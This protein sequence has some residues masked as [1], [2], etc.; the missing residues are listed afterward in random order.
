MQVAKQKI[1]DLLEKTIGLNVTAFS[2][3]TFQRALGTR[4]KALGLD[5]F[6]AYFAQVSV[7]LEELR[8]LVEEVVV[9][10]TWFLETRNLSFFWPIIF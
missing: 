1:A 7:S 3:A 9:P 10:E 2:N 8:R 5:D 6:T 4:M